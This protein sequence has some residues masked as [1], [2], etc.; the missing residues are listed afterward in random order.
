MPGHPVDPSFSLQKYA[1][2]HLTACM[3]NPPLP[4]RHDPRH[5]LSDAGKSSLNLLQATTFS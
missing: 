4:G 3:H 1:V 2:I 5:P